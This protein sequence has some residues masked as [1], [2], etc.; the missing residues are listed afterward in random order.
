[1]MLLFRQPTC[2]PWFILSACLWK[3]TC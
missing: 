3:C 2:A 1:M